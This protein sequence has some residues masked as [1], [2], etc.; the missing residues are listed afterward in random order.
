MSQKQVAPYGAW[1]SPITSDLIVSATV[2]LGQ[3]VVEGRDTYWVELRPT[4]GGRHCIVRRGPGG[5]TVD[6]TPPEFNARRRTR[7]RAC[8]R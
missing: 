6:L 1:K 4:E 7:A 2:G 5:E 3:I 8:G